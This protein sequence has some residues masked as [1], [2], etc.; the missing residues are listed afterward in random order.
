MIDQTIR[1]AEIREFT[2]EKEK[3]CESNDPNEYPKY[4]QREGPSGL[5]KPL[6]ECP[7]APHE[8]L[9]STL[10]ILP[11]QREHRVLVTR[12]ESNAFSILPQ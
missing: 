4:I 1:G 8:A 5:I 6:P 10:G 7:Q 12:K 2:K 9:F 3:K 11:G